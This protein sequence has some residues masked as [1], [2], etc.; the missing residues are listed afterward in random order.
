ML[1]VIEVL[2]DKTDDNAIYRIFNERYEKGKTPYKFYIRSLSLGYPSYRTPSGELNPFA[3]GW[4]VRLTEDDSTIG[5]ITKE[6]ISNKV[7]LSFKLEVAIHRKA[8]FELANSFIAEVSFFGARLVNKRIYTPE[9]KLLEEVKV[10]APK[11]A[12]TLAKHK[13]AWKIIKKMQGESESNFVNFDEIKKTTY[14]EFRDRVNFKMKES[15][16]EKTI[17]RIIDEGEAGLLD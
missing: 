3:K 14:G 4:E 6:V 1:K 15:W 7:L 16:G 17:S 10:K 9:G 5:I 11:R 13:E 12:D 2:L 8:F